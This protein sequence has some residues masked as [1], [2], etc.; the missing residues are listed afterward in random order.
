MPINIFTSVSL[1]IPILIMLAITA[2]LFLLYFNWKKP[3]GIAMKVIISVVLVIVM[4][5]IGSGVKGY[6]DYMSALVLYQILLSFRFSPGLSDNLNILVHFI[7][8]HIKICNA[9]FA[10][11]AD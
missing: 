11:Q 3:V 5:M 6:L 8:I 9:H 10:V 2:T 1:Y 4:V 7:N